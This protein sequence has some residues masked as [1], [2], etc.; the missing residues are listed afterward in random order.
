MTTSPETAFI[1]RVQA[2][3]LA[4][5]LVAPAKALSFIGEHAAGWVVLGVIGALIDAPHAWA[6]LWSTLA[7]VVAHGLSIV[8][9]RIVRRPRPGASG[10]P[11]TVYATAPSKLSF[12]SSHAS[13]TMAAAVVFT[14]FVPWLWPAAVIVVLFMGV[15]RVILGMHYPTDVLAGY[16]I[17]LIVGVPTVLLLH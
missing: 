7:V 3:P 2:T 12:P 4:R 11:V 15:S 9:K 13:S 8:I 17:G 16:L 6:W 14:A 1:V 10:G 5:G